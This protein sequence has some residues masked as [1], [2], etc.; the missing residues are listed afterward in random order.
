MERVLEHTAGAEQL[1]ARL[2]LMRL[3]E[4][5]P[6]PT[7]DLLFNLGLYCRSGLLVKFLV[8]ADLYKRVLNVPGMFVELGC[9]YGQNLALLQNLQAIYE[10]MNR[11]RKMVAFDTFTGYP[12]RP[13]FYSTGKKY[14]AHLAKLLDAQRRCNVYGHIDPGH[15]LIEGD[16][17][18]TVPRYFDQHDE[19]IVALA[20]V[21]I[22]GYEETVTSL[23]AIIP[24]LV[25]GSIVLFDELTL[26]G[27]KGEARAFRELF[28]QR[29]YRL[30]KCALYPS[31]S[32]LEVLP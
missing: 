7:A 27:G 11:T 19:A 25:P 1:R 26:D 15:E 32:I 18:E 3:F 14:K 23:E 20:Y 2:D 6:L 28:K 24:H 21:D 4:K 10:P 16:V 12:E 17:V 30:E 22:G 5:T 8:M 13:G 29:G 31:K 9:W